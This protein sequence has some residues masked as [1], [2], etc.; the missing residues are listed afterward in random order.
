MYPSRYGFE[1]DWNSLIMEAII[2]DMDGVLIDSEPVYMTYA[3]QFLEAEGLRYPKEKYLEKIGSAVSIFSDMSIY[4]PAMDIKKIYQKFEN[5]WKSI[6]LDYPAIYRSSVSGLLAEFKEK[7]IKLAIAS[8]SSL[9]SINEMV[10]S[11]GIQSYFQTIVSGRDLAESKP[12]PE[13]YLEAA[14]KLRVSPTDCL[15][16]EDS[17]NGILAGHRAGMKVVA[18][19]DTRF[20]QDTHLA[21]ALISDIAQLRDIVE[22]KH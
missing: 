22:N 14:K 5:Y 21:S 16:I 18:L 12:N 1:H 11:C 20:K 10:T 13:I 19:M 17:Y 2:F 8:S 7:E 3:Y 6:K 4:N 9:Q 15:V